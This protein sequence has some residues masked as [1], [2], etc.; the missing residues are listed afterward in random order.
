MTRFIFFDIDGPLVD[1]VEF[2]ARAW[3]ESFRH[4]GK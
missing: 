2:H 3:Q 1:S 4:L